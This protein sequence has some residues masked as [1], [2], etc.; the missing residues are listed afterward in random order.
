MPLYFFTHYF[1]QNSY[2][3]NEVKHMCP[4]EL[5]AMVNA[6]SLAIAKN[7]SLNELTI[8]SAVFTQIGDTLATIAAERQILCSSSQKDS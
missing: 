4:E 6:V 5:A 7:S 2:S 1:F 3:N 8:L